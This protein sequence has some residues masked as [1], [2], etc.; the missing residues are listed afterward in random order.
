[1]GIYSWWD[2]VIHSVQN[3][4]DDWFLNNFLNFSIVKYNR[5]EK[6]EKSEVFWSAS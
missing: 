4:F 5:V 6:C 3:T 2:E 1:M